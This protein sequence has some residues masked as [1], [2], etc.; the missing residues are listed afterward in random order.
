MH[1][2]VIANHI[3]DVVSL[4][5]F[6]PRTLSPRLTGETEHLLGTFAI[7]LALMAK[8]SCKTVNPSYSIE[9]LPF[10]CLKNGAKYYLFSSDG[11]RERRAGKQSG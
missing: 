8:I 3:V 10:F 7:S 1:A 6:D 2:A 11:R 5:L 9:Q 4:N